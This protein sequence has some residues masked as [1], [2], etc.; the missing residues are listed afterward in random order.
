MNRQELE[1]LRHLVARD[2]SGRW[3]QKAREL[4]TGRTVSKSPTCAAHMPFIRSPSKLSA[5]QVAALQTKWSTLVQKGQG[6]EWAPKPAPTRGQARPTG[7]E[8]VG[9]WSEYEFTRLKQI[10]A[11]EPQLAEHRYYDWVKI[12]NALVT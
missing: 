8:G 4:G 12:A 6:R 3:D 9:E 10:I 1:H 11:Q 5:S 7:K 2:G